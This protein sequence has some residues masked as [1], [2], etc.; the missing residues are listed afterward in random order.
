MSRDL[1][2]R[3]AKTLVGR[4]ANRMRLLE[5]IRATNARDEAHRQQLDAEAEEIAQDLK[6]IGN[7]VRATV[8][9]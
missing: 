2:D 5:K 9:R 4:V 6:A 3:K 1:G 7:L 8:P